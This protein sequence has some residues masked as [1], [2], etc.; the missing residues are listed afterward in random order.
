MIGKGDTR[1]EAPKV[2]LAKRSMSIDL[3]FGNST[4]RK[5]RTYF[6]DGTT[7]FDAYLDG[8]FA[9]AP[10]KKQHADPTRS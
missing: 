1:D 7:V 5:G 10:S 9:P 4:S 6:D 8:G 3:E 2:V